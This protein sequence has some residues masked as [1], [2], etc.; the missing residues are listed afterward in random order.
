[1]SNAVHTVVKARSR[2]LRREVVL[3]NLTFNSRACFLLRRH[4]LV[5]G[6]AQ[7]RSEETPRGVPTSRLRKPPYTV[8]SCFGN[9][10]ELP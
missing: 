8:F 7:T 4:K 5:C 9:G 10:R 3:S 2:T 6:A 1:M